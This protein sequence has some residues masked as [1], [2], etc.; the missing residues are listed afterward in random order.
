MHGSIHT[1]FQGYVVDQ[2]SAAAYDDIIKRAGYAGKEFDPTGYYA[3]VEMYRILDAAESVLGISSRDIL[4]QYGVW[5]TPGLLSVHHER[6]KPEW[7]AL[8]LLEATECVMHRFVIDA[9]GARPPVLRA[10]RAGPDELTLYYD[11]PR[12]MCTLGTGFVE[13]VARYYCQH[14][15]VEQTACMHRGDPCC[16]IVVRLNETPA[17]TI[18]ED[19]AAI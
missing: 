13:G 12:R 14:V 11:S 19:V 10:E 7:K 3:D 9:A 6:I 16:T 2:H 5:V 1:E 15:E 8:D 18:E 17:S 4:F